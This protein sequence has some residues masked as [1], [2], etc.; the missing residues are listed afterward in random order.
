M[1]T[2]LPPFTPGFDDL[3]DDL[4]PAAWPRRAEVESDFHARA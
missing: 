3:A 2:T 1:A 4:R